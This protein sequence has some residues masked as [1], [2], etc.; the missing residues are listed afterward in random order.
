MSR[1]RRLAPA[2]AA[3][4]LVAGADGS[5]QSLLSHDWLVLQP[6]VG[7]SYANVVAVSNDGLF[8]SASTTS[9]LA[10]R[11]SILAGMRF[12]PVTAGARVDFARYAAYDLGDAGLFVELRIPVPFIQPFG[13]VGVGYAWLGD[14]NADPRYLACGATG[15]DG[16]CPKVSG[17]FATV[18]GG[19]DL[20]ISSHFTLGANL[21]VNFLN[22]TRAAS[23]TSVMFAN[24]GDS[25]GLQLTLGLHAAL[26]I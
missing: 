26:R 20:A 14:L 7:L 10:P 25:V 22:L 4:A 18:G 5:A 8:P 15:T 23:P 17:W 12:G 24:T 19:V 2:L 11:L 1:A 6:E 13:R 3:A 21:D 16:S 9:G